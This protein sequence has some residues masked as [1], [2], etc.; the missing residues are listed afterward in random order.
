MR[1]DIMEKLK[2]ELTAVKEIIDKFGVFDIAYLD[3][4]SENDFLNGFNYFVIME[5]G[6]CFYIVLGSDVF[7]DID[8]NDIVYI[9][10]RRGLSVD[11]METT[12][13]YID[14]EDGEFDQNWVTDKDT[15][16]VKKFNTDF[17][18]QIDTGGYN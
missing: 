16:M 2:T 7:P 3:L 14:T 10:K 13:E 1:T 12:K 5:D 4:E 17:T 18:R 8:F 9:R 6:T 11:E 15:E